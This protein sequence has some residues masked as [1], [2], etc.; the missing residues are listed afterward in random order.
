MAESVALCKA[1]DVLIGAHP[2]LPDI[3]GFGRREMALS[4]EEHTAN[5]VYQVGALQAFLERED[6]PLNHVKPHG[7]LYGM[8]V[9]N[10]DVARAVWA[11]VPK[12]KGIKV[13]GLAGT[14]META[15]REAGLEFWAE[16]YSDVK[17]RKDGTL[18]VD[19]K[20]QPWDA[21]HVEAH[22]RQQCEKQQ[23]TAITGEVIDLPVKDYP[24]T[25]CCHSDTPGC[26]DVIKITRCIV[27]EINARDTV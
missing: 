14:H 1:H 16:Y 3:Q 23:V 13:F 21:E 8:M 10:L 11:G 15:A 2:G 20:K 24:L 18:I 4:M 17:Y 12:G 27:D 6:V 25:I 9:R 22:V 5:I 19:R 7:V 26:L